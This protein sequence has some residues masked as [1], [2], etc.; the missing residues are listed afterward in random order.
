MGAADARRLATEVGREVAAARRSADATQRYVAARAGISRSQLGRLER[1]ETRRPSLDVL[2][3]AARAAGFAPSLKLFPDG[4]RLRD[5]GQL[6]VLARFGRVPATPLSIRREVRLPV[7]GDLRAWDA[8]VTD[9]HANASVEA[10]VHLN[11]VQ[12]VQRRIALKQRDDPGAGVLILLMANTV[13]NRRVLAQ[14][15]EALRAQFPLDGGRILRALR[16][17]RL[18]P[19]SGI[20]LL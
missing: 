15:R 6:T 1:G 18:P 16:A 4:A 2:C 13:H 7:P 10:E 3:R 20:L 8:R 9:G 12:E 11:D 14:H 19:A 5:V 17:G